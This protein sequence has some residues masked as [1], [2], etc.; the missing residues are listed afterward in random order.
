MDRTNTLECKL[1]TL[2]NFNSARQLELNLNFDS[3][4]PFKS[5]ETNCGTNVLL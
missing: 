1:A 5:H 3:V 4:S 2:A